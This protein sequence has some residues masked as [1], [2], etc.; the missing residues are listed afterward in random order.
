M[1]MALPGG[2]AA[3]LG[4]RYEKWWTL[5]EF[6]RLLHG[7]T[8]AICIED[9][10]VE[11][12]EFVVTTGSGRELHQVKRSHPSG[13]WSL[14]ALRTHGLLEV[15]GRQLVGNDDRFVFTSGSEARKLRDLCDAAKAAESAEEFELVFLAAKERKED[16]RTLLQ[17][18]DCDPATAM[19]VLARIDV[20]TIDE[21]G[22]EST[23]PMGN[24]GALSGNSR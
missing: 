14:A 22:L 17:D 20:R 4:N 11:K 10:S 24:T 15:M 5:S 9:P 19:N 8:D 7:E 21:P 16:F 23:V 2:A 13:K 6:V 1:T 18:W 12:A 3:K